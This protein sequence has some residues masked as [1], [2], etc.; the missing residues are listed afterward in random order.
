MKA[1]S[2]KAALRDL[3]RA[4]IRPII[5]LKG[6]SRSNV[7]ENWNRGDTQPLAHRLLG[8]MKTAS[9][10]LLAS[11]AYAA[12][13]TIRPDGVF[14]FDGKP[15]FPIG[16]TTAPAPGAAAPSGGAAYAELAKNG[17]A[18][19]RCGVG[20]K[21]GPEAEATLDSIMDRAGK[22]GLHCAIYVPD[23]TVIAPG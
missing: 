2:I 8:L 9:L 1:K 12:V 19:N 18:F 21:W 23:L 10:L 11:A 20:G 7:T 4:I 17:V 16:F 14:L 6:V 15:A 5:R 3:V 22:T 13:V